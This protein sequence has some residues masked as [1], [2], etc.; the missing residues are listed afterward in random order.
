MSKSKTTRPR[1][2]QISI[3]LFVMNK[4][5]AGK[6]SRRAAPRKS[7]RKTLRRHRSKKSKKGG[8]ALNPWPVPNTDHSQTMKM[9]NSSFGRFVGSP[10]NSADPWYAESSKG[11]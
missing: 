8:A 9:P 4:E 5:M 7:R 2:I 6:K 1:R 11:K 3:L 10:E